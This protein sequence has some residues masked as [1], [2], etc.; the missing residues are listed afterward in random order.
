MWGK[1]KA[2]PRGQHNR[3]VKK[4]ENDLIETIKYG[5]KIFSEPNPNAK[6]KKKV[7][8]YVYISALYNIYSSMRGLRLFERF[9]FQKVETSNKNIGIR[10]NITD[11][12]SYSYYPEHLDWVND[13]TGETLSGFT[14]DHKLM[15]LLNHRINS[16]LE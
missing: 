15:N 16:T 10:K 11:F 2:G 8:R 3:R 6:N 12:N 5:S 13:E 14:P 9:G 1:G 4:L 7:S